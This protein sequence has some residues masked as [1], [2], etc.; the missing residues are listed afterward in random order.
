MTRNI[1][2]IT[3]YQKENTTQINLRLSKKYDEDIIYALDGLDEGKATYIK[4]LIRKDM[5]RAKSPSERP[6]VHEESVDLKHEE[7]NKEVRDM[8]KDFIRVEEM[9][10][11][12]GISVPTINSWYRFK[13]ENPDNE[14]AKL[15]PEFER[16]GAHR[17]RCWREEDVEKLAFFKSA[18]PQGRNGIMGSITQRYVKKDKSETGTE[19]IAEVVAV[20]EKNNVEEG[21]IDFIRELLEEEHGKRIAA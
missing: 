5:E 6:E 19:Y 2:Y 1:T 15:I 11:R 20:L 10:V 17:E 7:D 4:Q 21:Y 14:F 8:T 12:L 16:H 13:K 18:I 3:K 9:A